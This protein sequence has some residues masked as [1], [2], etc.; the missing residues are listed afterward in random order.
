MQFN[1]VFIKLSECGRLPSGR[2]VL[3]ISPIFPLKFLSENR[4]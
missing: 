4:H 1:K 2:I 3:Q